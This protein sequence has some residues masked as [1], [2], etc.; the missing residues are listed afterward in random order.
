MATKSL[1]HHC[2][3]YFKSSGVGGAHY[4]YVE[5]A[6]ELYWIDLRWGRVILTRYKTCNDLKKK[7]IPVDRLRTFIKK[8]FLTVADPYEWKSKN[9]D[10]EECRLGSLNI[11]TRTCKE[12]T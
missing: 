5:I 7:C 3:L 6:K 10:R 9:S 11:L 1:R 4:L 8:S 2:R 12:A